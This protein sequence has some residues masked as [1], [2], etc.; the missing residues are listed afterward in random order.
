MAITKMNVED[1][2][3]ATQDYKNKSTEFIT[4]V[5]ALES[6]MFNLQG[7][8]K[9][10]AEQAYETQARELFKN[11]RSITNSIDGA[12]ERVEFAIQQYDEV[13]GQNQ[14]AINAVDEG[15]ADYGF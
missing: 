9:G 3:A 12:V 13:E 2:R 1:A 6:T 15:Q 10:A 7:T 8:W 5:Q 4:A 14:S 11:L